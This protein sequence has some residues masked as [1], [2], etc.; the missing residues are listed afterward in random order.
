MDRNNDYH[1]FRRAQAPG[2]TRRPPQQP[3]ETI[4]QHDELIRYIKEAWNQVT[5]HGPHGGP[6][7]YRCE[8]APPHPPGFT[9]FDLDSYWGQ[10]VIPNIHISS[11]HH[12]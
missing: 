10:R 11:G 2:L 4:T 8:N 7:F 9:P 12:Q 1:N 6:V 3:R 5:E